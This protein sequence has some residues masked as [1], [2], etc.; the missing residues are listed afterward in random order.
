MG[1]TLIWGVMHVVNLA[2][3]AMI[4][5]GM[6]AL[7]YLSAAIGASPYVAILPIA[8]GGLVAGIGLYWLAVHRVVGQTALMSLLSTF[9]VNMMLIGA[10]TVIWGTAVYNVSLSVPG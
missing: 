9:A 6:F 5:A 7:L 2:H 8:A 10:G 3:G 1:L 4:W